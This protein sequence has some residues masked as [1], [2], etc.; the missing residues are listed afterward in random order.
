MSR[1][2]SEWGDRSR[3]ESTYDWSRHPRSSSARSLHRRRVSERARYRRLLA[4][5]LGI[6]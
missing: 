5:S 2:V 1:L 4:S 3:G 6:K